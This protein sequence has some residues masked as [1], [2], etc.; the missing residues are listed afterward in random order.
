MFFYSEYLLKWCP[1]ENEF[2]LELEHIS[3]YELEELFQN[4]QLLVTDDIPRGKEKSGLEESDRYHLDVLLW[5]FQERVKI[6][7][8]LFSVAKVILYY[9]PSFQRQRRVGVFFYQ[10]E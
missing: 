10:L 5:I 6:I 9:N 7:N 8:I 2:L 4:Y 3:K 1:I